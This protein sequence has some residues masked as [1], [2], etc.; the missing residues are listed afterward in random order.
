MEELR[1]Q[2]V[3]CQQVCPDHDLEEYTCCCERRD[4]KKAPANDR[5][6]RPE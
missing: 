4:K 2:R 6:I 5:L 3:L 1:G